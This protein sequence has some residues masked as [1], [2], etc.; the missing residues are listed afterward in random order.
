MAHTIQYWYDQIFAEK[1][2]QP[3]LSGITT[4]SRLS[5][6]GAIAYVFAFMAWLVETMFDEHKAEIIALLAKDRA[7]I[8]TWYRTMAR[9]FQYGQTFNRD[10]GKYE[11]I[12][13]TDEQ[14]EAQKIIVQAAVNEVVINGSVEV[15]IK[16][17]R[18]VGGDFAPIDD[19]QHEAMNAYIAKRKDG[20]V[21]AIIK[22]LPAD[23]LKLDLDIFY[24]PL[25]L[26]DSG[27]RIDGNA[28][29]PVKDAINEYLKNLEFNGEYANNRLTDK[30]QAV[31]GIVL[32]VVKT[33]WAKYGLFTFSI[34]DERYI[35]DAGYI[36]LADADLNIQWR[37]YV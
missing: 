6:F 3:A 27:Q 32:P 2:R 10:L 19:D 13:L 8:V 17:V 25:V 15:T 1:D 21:N 36:R 18:L 26:N 7:H 4:T 31:D 22:S 11:N 23:S 9:E 33:A 30:L 29:A 5:I 12:G 14:V 37:P 34:I 16:V 28:T 35:P 20:G 24:D